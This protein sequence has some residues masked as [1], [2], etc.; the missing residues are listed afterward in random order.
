MSEWNA[1]DRRKTS[2]TVN[3]T[4][5]WGCEGNPSHLRFQMLQGCVYHAAYEPTRYRTDKTMKISYPGHSVGATW[6]ALLIGTL[7]IPL[8]AYWVMGLVHQGYPTTVSLFFNVIFWL[9]ILTGLNFGLARLTSRYALKQ[10]ELLTVYVMLSLSSAIAGHDMLR[11]LIPSI[12]FAFWHASPEN[13]WAELFHRYIPDWLAVKDT[14]V[15][16]DFYD[17][18]PDDLNFQVKAFAE[19][20]M[21][22]TL[23]SEIDEMLSFVGKKQ[24][25]QWIWLAM[26]VSSRQI[27]SAR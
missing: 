26:D 6:R 14:N 4:A 20:L 12:P 27:T 8:N 18:L 5:K 17:Q 21:I 19:E 25:K 13:E 9:F 24:N 22:Y 1:N 16:V 10:G 2:P 15:V 3:K 7:L 23:E 11:V